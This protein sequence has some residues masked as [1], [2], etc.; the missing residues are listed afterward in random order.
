MQQSVSHILHPPDSAIMPWWYIVPLYAIILGGILFLHHSVSPLLIVA[1]IILI[2]LTVYYPE[3][4]LVAFVFIGVTKPWVDENIALFQ[5]IDYT[6]FLAVYILLLL[7]ITVVRRETLTM[8]SFLFLLPA[9][10]LLSVTLFIGVIYTPAASYGVDKAAS[11]FVFNILLFIATI[12]YIKDHGDIKRI[13]IIVVAGTFVFAMIM[14]HQGL[15][16][17]LGG[18]L[19]D[20]II[21]M[22]ILGANP[23][24]SARI[25]SFAFLIVLIAAY[26]TKSNRA[27]VF[28]YLLSGY[29]LVALIVTNTRGPLVS[30]LAAVLFFALFL[31]D[32]KIKTIAFYVGSF[33]LVIISALLILPDFVTSRYEVLLQ[34]DAIQQG[35]AGGEIDTIGS[36]LLMWSM[37]FSG[38]LDS[39]WSFLFGHGTGSFASLF[40]FIDFRWYPHNI[41]AEVMYEIGIIGLL[42][43]IFH[44]GQIS[45]LT[46]N[47]WT[48]TKWDDDRK[49]VVAILIISAV[50]AFFAALVSGDINDNRFLWF[51][52]GLIVANWRIIADQ[53]RNIQH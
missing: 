12:L 17:F 9:L 42:V 30:T 24:A 20:M 1:G 47:V 15:Q 31:S 41:F 8:P 23:I 28:L 49:T 44:F 43:L 26:F 34:A 25:F 3:I 19:S 33:I 18:N 29:F 14:F 7:F 51:H 10:V 48:E 38:S 2:F 16:S 4:P 6:V 22:T 21:R 27:K 52:F 5:A 32:M 45:R 46:R 53:K 36:R 40:H 35:I 50:A 13:L 11:F 37:A 39:L